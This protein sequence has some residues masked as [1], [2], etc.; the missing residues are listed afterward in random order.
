MMINACAFARY[1]RGQVPAD[2]GGPINVRSDA[3][4]ARRFL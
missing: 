1:A 3:S 2:L 4:T